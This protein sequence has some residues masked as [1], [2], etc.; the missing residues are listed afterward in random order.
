MN[1][2]VTLCDLHD[3]EEP[4]WNIDLDKPC[5]AVASTPLEAL[6]LVAAT[7]YPH[8]PTYPDELVPGSLSYPDGMLKVQHG[9]DTAQLRSY[10][11]LNDVDALAVLDYSFQDDLEKD[12]KRMEIV[13]CIWRLL[14]DPVTRRLLLD[15]GLISPVGRCPFVE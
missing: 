10:R 8:F 5:H 2:E 1:V 12:H 13:D 15:W 14:H 11:V 4:Q 9:R 6:L 7:E 3:S